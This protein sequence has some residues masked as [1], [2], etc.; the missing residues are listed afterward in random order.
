MAEVLHLLVLGFLD[1]PVVAVVE[2]PS[3]NDPLARQF[4]VTVEA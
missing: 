4:I 2:R 1:K 3:L